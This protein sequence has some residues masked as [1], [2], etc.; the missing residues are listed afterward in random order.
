[1]LDTAPAAPGPVPPAGFPEPPPRDIDPTADPRPIDLPTNEAGTTRRSP[2]S[3][4]PLNE[5]QQV[6]EMFNRARHARRPLIAQWKK[7]YR[8]LTNKGWAEQAEPWIPAPKIPQI[9]PVALSWIGW[10]TD[11]R[12]IIEVMPAAQPFS[13]FADFYMSL[14]EDM[15]TLMSR[16]FNEYLLDAELTKVLWDEFCYGIGYTKTLWRHTLA[17]GLG[18]ATFDR[19]DPFTLYPDPYAKTP[20]DLTYIIEARTM[21]VTDL[22]RCYPGA[23]RLIAGNYWT[24]DTDEAPHKLDDTVSPT[25]PR[26]RMG[27]LNGAATRWTNQRDERT[28]GSI[29]DEPVV[30]V[31]EC[32]RRY[33][34]TEHQDDGTSKVIDGWWL[35]VVVND[36]VVMSV[37]S[38]EVNAYG[39][40]PYDRCVLVDTGEWYGPSMVEF[41]ASAQTSIN[42]TLSNIESNIALMGNPV[43]R[44]DPRA[45][46]RHTRI[47]N[48]PGQRIPARA[49]Q[50]N[51]LDPPQMNPQIAVQLMSFYKGEIESISGLSAMVRGFSPTGRNSEGVLDSV[52]DAA[53]VRVRL[54]LREL[55]RM[56]RGIAYKMASTMAEFYTEARTV[57][58][59][60]PDGQETIKILR[61]R[62]FYTRDAQD[63][64]DQQP[65]RF[66]V[67]A[68]AGS[69]LPTSRQARAAEA[70][71]LYAIGAIDVY[72]LLKA[73]QWPNWAV[74]SKRVMEMQAQSG[75]L[76][77]PPGARQRAGRNQ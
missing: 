16:A 22:D 63:P 20:R 38:S 64:N 77:Q 70:E 45:Q 74:V 58:T 52:Q 29:Y 5:A 3:R 56:M 57:A 2:F 19:I 53:F 41:L 61:S 11:Q 25:G 43:L 4:N 13:P 10:M 62:H 14:A 59:I 65:L 33:H 35:S 73:K 7:N 49:D 50:V 51:W 26:V 76:G 44:E 48:R 17:D 24:E 71:R 69:Q 15:N 37:D 66:A 1:M 40:H 9:F 60:G 21:T 72:E 31:L 39:G 54:H 28:G 12:P 55:E 30:T 8:T 67:V 68:D 42:R 75:T 23:E 36:I 32:W 34:V 6:R 47:S 46:S 18:D 27:S